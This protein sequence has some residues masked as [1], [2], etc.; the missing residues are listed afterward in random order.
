M[1]DANADLETSKSRWSCP[2]IT[3]N[4]ASQT[5]KMDEF[6]QLICE[7]QYVPVPHTSFYSFLATV[8][9]ENA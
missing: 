8:Q 3:A 4:N 1:N 9:S 6:L 2:E 7:S 5:P